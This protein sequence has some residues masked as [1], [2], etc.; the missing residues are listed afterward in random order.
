MSTAAFDLEKLDLKKGAHAQRDAGVCLM[1]AVA[2][3]AN[4]PHSDRPQCACPV[5]TSFGISLNDRF[6][7]EER[8]LLKPLI[9]KL[10]G[11]RS[12]P[13][14]QTKRAYFLADKS[15]RVFTPMALRAA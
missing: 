9:P 8:Q 12:T 10:V 5:L 3:F 11:T 13:E 4:E 6:S 7:A 1:E 2:W 15:I 14:I